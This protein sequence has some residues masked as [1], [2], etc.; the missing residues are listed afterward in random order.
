MK[1]TIKHILLSTV[2][3]LLL[4]LIVYLWFVSYGQQQNDN[5]RINYVEIEDIYEPTFTATQL[6]DKLESFFEKAQSDSLE[7]MFLEWNSEIEPNS[8]VFISQNEYI[9]AVFDVYKEFYKPLGILKFE[10]YGWTSERNSKSKYV[11]VQNKIFFS[12]LNNDNLNSFK[13]GKSQ[14]D[15]IV[16][17]RPP[18]SLEKDKV[19]YLTDEYAD[20]L[21]IFLGTESTKVGE[22]GLM[23][24]SRPKG[25]SVGRYEMLLP[26]IPIL[27]GH[28][29]GYWHLET[30]P[31]V[32]IIIFN[33]TLTKAEV[34]FRIDYYGGETILEKEGER[35]VIKKS[36]VTWIE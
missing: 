25:E 28:W 30:Y 33:K 15:S 16:N 3:L 2:I 32:R 17:F 10:D 19:L 36:E 22:E 13:W 21:N 4:L 14:K 34:A 9:N 24:P 5:N 1:A 6:N 31:Y 18:T 26:Y 8:D 12:I 20:A 11:V 35:W 23:N 7:K 27:H 29:G